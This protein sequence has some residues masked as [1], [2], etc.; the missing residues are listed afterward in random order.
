MQQPKLKVSFKLF[1]FDI[2]GAI[3]AAFGLLS[4]VGEGAQVHP[5]LAD[6]VHGAILLLAGL[7]LMGCFM[8]DL[9]KRIRAQRKS[10]TNQ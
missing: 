4:V 8:F 3:M 6:P 5:W 10:R 7:A 2:I 1:V 9:F